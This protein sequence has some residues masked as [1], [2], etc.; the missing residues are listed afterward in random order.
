M[1]ERSK[2]ARCGCPNAGGNMLD[3]AI[4]EKIKSLAS[5]KGSFLAQLEKSRPFYSGNR[6][7]CEI[8]LA[9]LRA[10]YA[11]NERTINGLVDSLALA[12]DTAAR[13]RILNRV[14][15]C[16]DANRELEKRLAELEEQ[17]AAE[18]LGDADIDRLRRRLSRF[19]S[20]VEGM[21]VE[22]KRTAI[23][24]IIRKVVWDG[25]NA[26]VVLFGAEETDGAPEDLWCE[27]SK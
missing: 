25:G 5:H 12:G 17:T 16:G 27:G 10:E 9:S 8:H 6:E 14:V 1:K 15:Q 2:G 11:A 24:T 18:S 26:H 4:L 20:S 23:R 13:T 3:A 7:P 19:H 22:E 21:S